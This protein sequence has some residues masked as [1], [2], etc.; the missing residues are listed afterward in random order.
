[1]ATKKQRRRR[2][3]EHRHEWETVYVDAEG[4]EVEAPESEAPSANGRAATAT[5][6]KP[7]AAQGQR[8]VQPPS[9]RRVGKRGLLFAPAMFLLMTF[10]EPN[11][12]ILERSFFTL[13]L[14]A[15]FLPFSYVMDR[16]TYRLWQKRA[17]RDGAAGA[18]A[19]KPR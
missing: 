10:L 18:T 2:A 4:N 7:A 6:K 12:T 15:I 19:A 5:K 16:M 9:W 8:T 11:T 3:K 17:A 14:L 1:M 13:Q